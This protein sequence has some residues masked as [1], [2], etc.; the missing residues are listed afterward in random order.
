MVLEN[1]VQVNVTTSNFHTNAMHSTPTTELQGIARQK[2]RMIISGIVPG[3]CADENNL[4]NQILSGQSD[5]GLSIAGD[6]FGSA[7]TLGAKVIDIFRVIAIR[8]SLAL[9]VLRVVGH[10]LGRRDLCQSHEG[11]KQHN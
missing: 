8:I 2:N 6:N 3:G 4:I 10:V 9:V 7:N 11:E 1:Y 5:Q